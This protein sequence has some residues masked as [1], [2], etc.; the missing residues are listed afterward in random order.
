MPATTVTPAAITVRLRR[1][2]AV[3]AIALFIGIVFA[4]TIYALPPISQGFS[5]KEPLPL[6]A[7]VS[8]Q[9]SSVD[10][11]SATTTS[12]LDSIYGVVINNA[13]TPLS[14]SNGS[15]DQV[16]IATSGVASV[17]I[18]DINGQ[19][20]KGDHI[21]ASPLKG[22]GM[23]ATRN[24]KIIG[25]AQDAPRY[26]ADSKQEYT[27]TDGSK[28]SVM[29]G[30]AP[31]LVNV[32]YF[33][34]TPE[35]TIIP[36][37]IQNLANALAGKTVDPL[38]IIISAA[39]FII[40]LVVVASIIYSMIRSSIIS[41]G[42]NPMAQSAVYRGVLQLSALVIGILAAAMVVIYIILTRF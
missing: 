20:E 32:A 22:V 34:K 5:A 12:N 3:S 4:G 29:I 2:F 27:D 24:T 14:L 26:T 15:A 37:A 25:I 9:N 38:P 23:K 10:L 13:G 6:G 42:R 8:L 7:I 39:I 35:K 18:S 1:V 41:V 17:L 31:V 21:T 30:E 16:H 19:V 28:K 40:T 33:Y 11:V 36:G